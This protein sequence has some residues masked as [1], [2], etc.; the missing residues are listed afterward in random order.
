LRKGEKEKNFPR[1][2]KKGV[3]LGSSEKRRC[4]VRSG[5]EGGEGRGS[6]IT[7]LLDKGVEALR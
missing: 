1:P 6:G 7:P 2:D 3:L 4:Q 5:R